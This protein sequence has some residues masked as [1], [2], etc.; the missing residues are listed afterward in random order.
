[1]TGTPNRAK[2]AFVAS[3]ATKSVN[4]RSEERT[5]WYRLVPVNIGLEKK[6]FFFARLSPV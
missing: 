3:K 6:F 4:F 5:G 1:M 2:C